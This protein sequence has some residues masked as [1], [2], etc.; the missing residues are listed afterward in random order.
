MPTITQQAEALGLT[1]NTMQERAESLG[2]ILTQDETGFRL[3][4]PEKFICSS[5]N[6]DVIKR[7]LDICQ[8]IS[9]SAR[10]ATIKEVAEHF[11]EKARKADLQQMDYPVDSSRRYKLRE[12]CWESEQAASEILSLLEKGNNG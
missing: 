11:K 8:L 10:S 4:H 2:L 7:H 5:L 12:E 1:E 3:R 6:K 9:E